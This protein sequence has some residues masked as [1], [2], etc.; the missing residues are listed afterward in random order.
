MDYEVSFQPTDSK[1]SSYSYLN[2]LEALARFTSLVQ[3]TAGHYVEPCYPDT[4]LDWRGANGT[5]LMLIV[6]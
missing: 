3:G 1:W 5:R 6:R 2:K 4:L